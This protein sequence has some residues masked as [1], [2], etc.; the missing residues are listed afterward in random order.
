MTELKPC[1][2]CGAKPQV[3]KDKNAAY[4]RVVCSNTKCGLA[5]T[6]IDTKEAAITA[7]NTRT[8]NKH[9][10]NAQMWALQLLKSCIVSGDESPTA[11]Y[12]WYLGERASIRQ[13]IGELEIEDAMVEQ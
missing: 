13:V 3:W 4:H 5:A 6:L 2:F 8:N 1:P 11:L 12:N 10:P 7:W 9:Q